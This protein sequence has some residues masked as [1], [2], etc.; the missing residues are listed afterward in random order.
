[1]L[2]SSGCEYA[3]RALTHLAQRRP[4]ELVQLREI[5]EAEDI[6]APFLGKIL[7]DLVRTGLLRSV[8][9][10]RG[11]YGLARAPNAVTLL[12]VKAAVDGTGDLERC[13]VGLGR[14]S[15][16]MPCPLHDTFKPLRQAIRRY[17]ETT[18]LADM[19]R[20]LIR[21]RA[22]LAATEFAALGRGKDRKRPRGSRRR[23]RAG[24]GRAP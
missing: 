4:A 6:P 22:L 13:A 3:I 9:G 10:P 23:S 15:D 1:V 5:T 14:C 24:R 7:Q 19:A 8:K 18:T 21:K 2:Y 12:D 11:G 17:L 20:G 16:E